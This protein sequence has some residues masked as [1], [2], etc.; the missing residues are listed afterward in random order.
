MYSQTC[1]QRPTPGPLKSGRCSEVVAIQ[2]VFRT[3]RVSTGGTG[4]NRLS[5]W[6]RPFFKTKFVFVCF[7]TIADKLVSL[8]RR[9]RPVP[10][11]LTGP[12]LWAL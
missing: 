4:H 10:P 9:R 12:D 5:D 8:G 7:E 1:L 6:N 11:V 2:R 3:E